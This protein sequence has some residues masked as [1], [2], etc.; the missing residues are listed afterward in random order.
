MGMSG[1]FV[2]AGSNSVT[3]H[4]VPGVRN[5]PLIEV[6]DYRLLRLI[7]GVKDA[8]NIKRRWVEEHAF[9]D[10]DNR[11]CD[12]VYEELVKLKHRLRNLNTEKERR[13]L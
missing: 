12:I 13:G 2:S 10:S 7:D 3:E 5:T 1:R 4:F 8:I 9:P 6:S 11:Y